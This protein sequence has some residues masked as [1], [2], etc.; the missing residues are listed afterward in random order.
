MGDLPQRPRT[1]AVCEW[2][3]GRS[4]LQAVYERLR[5]IYECLRVFTRWQHFGALRDAIALESGGVQRMGAGLKGGDAASFCHSRSVSQSVGPMQPRGLDESCESLREFANS[6]VCESCEE[7]ASVESVARVYERLRVFA[8]VARVCESYESLRA[9]ASVYERL[10]V[11]TSVYE[12]LREN[13]LKVNINY[14]TID[15]READGVTGAGHEC[16]PEEK[17]EPVSL[18]MECGRLS[19]DMLFNWKK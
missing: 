3:Q 18:A 1:A 13:F 8:R 11:L 15:V 17:A 9:F 19:K 14:W 10:R 6:D 4:S 16:V 12:R 5:S 2:E 7:F